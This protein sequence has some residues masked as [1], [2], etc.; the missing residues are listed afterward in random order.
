VTYWSDGKVDRY[1]FLRALLSRLERDNW[2]IRSDTGWAEYDLEILEARW[3]RLRLITVPEYLESGRLNLRCR[4]ETEWSLAAKVA[5]WLV[6][7]GDL[8]LAALV[9]S[10]QPWIWMLLLTIPLLGWLLEFQQIK[11]RTAVAGLLDDVAESLRLVRTSQAQRKEPVSSPKVS[12]P[13][14]VSS[15]L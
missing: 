11:L 8:F 2:Q 5:F 7:A 13:A 4:L 10:K 12:R 1:A 3:A 14:P 6:F 15:I 9:G